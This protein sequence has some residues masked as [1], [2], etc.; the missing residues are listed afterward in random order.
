MS[1]STWCSIAAVILVIGLFWLIQAMQRYYNQ[2][3]RVLTK[4]MKHAQECSY[5]QLSLLMRE[6]MEFQ[7]S[8]PLG[9]EQMVRVIVIM[10]YIQW[11]MQEKK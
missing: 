6:V 7:S 3:N 8:R 4:F 9:Y 10:G 11:R 1:T 5:D 2:N